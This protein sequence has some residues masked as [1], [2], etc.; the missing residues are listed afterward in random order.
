MNLGLSLNYPAQYNNA[1]P[2]L[3]ALFHLESDSL[4]ELIPSV[5][6][7]VLFRLLL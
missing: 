5:P 1:P 2:E 6:D 7:I 3:Q 4:L